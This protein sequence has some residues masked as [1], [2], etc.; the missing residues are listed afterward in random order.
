MEDVV[1]ITGILYTVCAGEFNQYCSNNGWCGSG[2]EFRKDIRYK[3]DWRENIPDGCYAQGKSIVVKSD[4][5][6]TSVSASS[7]DAKSAVVADCLP[8]SNNGRCGPK[9][10]H[11]VCFSKLNQYCSR[12]GWCG[13]GYRFRKDTTNYK[14]W[15]E[16]IPD[17]CYG[18]GK[19][20]LI[21]H[22]GYAN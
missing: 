15:R 11:S 21:S 1:Q 19:S 12:N 3:N 5:A 13:S 7:D 22:L 10:G 20:I 4:A 8:R 16:S 14:Y 17:G 2:Y 6:G 18:K 9:Y